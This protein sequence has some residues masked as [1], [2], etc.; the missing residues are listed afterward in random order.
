MTRLALALGLMGLAL[1]TG[2]I[3]YQG[4]AVVFAA[5]AGERACLADSHC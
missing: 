5:V 1:A 2:L 4:F 3:A